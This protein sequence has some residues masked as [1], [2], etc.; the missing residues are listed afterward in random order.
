MRPFA[1]ST[2]G[3]ADEEKGR[4]EAAD[5]SEESEARRERCA[6][7]VRGDDPVAPGTCQYDMREQEEGREKE[8]GRKGRKRKKM[9]EKMKI[10]TQAE[11]VHTSKM[12]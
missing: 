2:D 11:S 3:R 6:R 12:K 1:I 8:K 5:G 10:K 7:V 9:K 4:K